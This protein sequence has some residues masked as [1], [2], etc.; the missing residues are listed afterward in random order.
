MTANPKPDAVTADLPCHEY[1]YAA[2]VD[3]AEAWD[4]ISAKNAEIARLREH[5][6]E[7][8]R[9]RD[10]ARAEALEEAAKVC[11][12]MRDQCGECHWPEEAVIV[13]SNVLH[14][15][16]SAIRARVTECPPVS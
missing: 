10:V 16:A 1:G 4:A 11:D 9:Q 13:G 15:A 14:D 2:D 7:A 6:A 12:H 3:K 8:E 5:L